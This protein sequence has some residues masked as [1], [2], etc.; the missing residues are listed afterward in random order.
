LLIAAECADASAASWSCGYSLA[1]A[2][3]EVTAKALA[4]AA[5]VAISYAWANCKVDE[6]GYACASAGSEISVWVG[7]V[8]ESWA[9]L[10]A[11]AYTCTGTC[12]VNVDAVVSAVGHILVDAATEAYAALC[13]SA[14]LL[15][16]CK[17]SLRWFIR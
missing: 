4:K 14:P 9:S 13:T 6:G 16:A 5:A 3:A 17:C 11:G 15:P 7:A 10:W 12:E 8:A 2:E 1:I